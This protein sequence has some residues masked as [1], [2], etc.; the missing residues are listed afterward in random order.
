MIWILLIIYQIKHF[1]ADYP[2]QGKYMLGKFKPYPDYIHPLLCHALV[3]GAFTFVI[4][5]FVNPDKAVFCAIL[6]IVVHFIVDRIK[7]SPDLLGRFQALSKKEYMEHAR[8]VQ[9]LSDAPVPRHPEIQLALDNIQRDFEPKLKSN[10]YFWWALGADQ[11]AHHL[12]HYA[13]IAILVMT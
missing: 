6:D 8:T 9:S 7:A 5:C 2:L 10:T 11:M 13:I 3:H 4:A 1:L 12:T